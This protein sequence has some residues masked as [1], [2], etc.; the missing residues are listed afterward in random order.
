[1]NDEKSDLLAL[2]VDIVSSYAGHNTI[3]Q[4]DLPALIASVH[5]ALQHASAPTKNEPVVLTPA[6]PV[7]KSI[8]HDH[9]VSLESGRKFKSLKRY[10]RVNYD[11][12]PEDYR[13]K[14]NLP[15][16]YPMVAPAYSVQR[17]KLALA[18]GLGRPKKP[19]PKPAKTT[20][21]R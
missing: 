1:M 8:T 3:P 9:I 19:A 6:V 10:L 17:S 15:A 5:N 12:S 11:M 16:D 20:K 18:A 7:K 4:T 13:S 2:T 21:K 14:W